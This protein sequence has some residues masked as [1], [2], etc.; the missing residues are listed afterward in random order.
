[1]WIIFSLLSITS[2]TASSIF[3]KKRLNKSDDNKA[4]VLFYS[5]FVNA[6]FF[7][8]IYFFDLTDGVNPIEVIIKYP[9]VLICAIG[10]IGYLLFSYIGLKY[11]PLSKTAPFYNFSSI[12][13]FFM[14]IAVYMVTG[15]NLNETAGISPVKIIATIFTFAAMISMFVIEKIEADRDKESGST[16]FKLTIFGYIM[17]FLG[18]FSDALDVSSSSYVLSMTDI[19]EYEI[20]YVYSFFSLIYCVLT[21]IYLCFKN[22][23]IYNPI[24]IKKEYYAI[25]TG[26]A[27]LLGYIFYTLA[28]SKSPMFAPV[29]ISTVSVF[30]LMSGIVILKEKIRKPYIIAIS[31]VIISLFIFSIEGIF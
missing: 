11:L 27:G 24:D 21:Y 7:F 31:L 28:Q 13:T 20:L 5:Y 16:A 15:V 6:L 23:G 25:V 22:K 3:T 17:I 29:L 10:S 8:F 4:I 12:F 1:M 2:Y 30:E 18:V 19:S 14:L 26:V 9:P